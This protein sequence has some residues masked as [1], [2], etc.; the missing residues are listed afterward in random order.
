VAATG[1][2]CLHHPYTVPSEKQSHCHHQPSALWM[3]TKKQMR[4]TQMLQNRAK[5]FLCP[6]LLKQRIY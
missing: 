1:I 3:P 6:Q 2:L 4:E 5:V